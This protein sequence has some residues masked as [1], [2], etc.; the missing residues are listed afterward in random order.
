[1][2]AVAR[3]LSSS[4]TLTEQVELTEEEPLVT[5]RI[6]SPDIR[7]GDCPMVRRT[8]LRC[9]RDGTG[10]RSL[11]RVSRPHPSIGH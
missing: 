7:R 3:G 8:R 9:K 4:A 11:T 6:D 2:K 1:M 10:R 5:I